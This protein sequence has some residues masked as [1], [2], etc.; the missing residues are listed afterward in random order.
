LYCHF[1]GAKTSTLADFKLP[2]HGTQE[3]AATCSIFHCA[4]SCPLKCIR[5]C[6]SSGEAME[7]GPRLGGASPCNTRARTPASWDVD[8]C[9]TRTKTR[10]PAGPRR[11]AA[12]SAAQEPT[13]CP[14]QRHRHMEHGQGSRFFASDVQP[15]IPPITGK[16]WGPIQLSHSHTEHPLGS[17][18]QAAP[19]GHLQGG[20]RSWG[21]CDAT[22]HLSIQDPVQ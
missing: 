20:R 13:C 10:P 16:V 15:Q 2:G 6:R 12:R 17:V 14:W 18:G 4:S 5:A 1:W 21:C 8:S 9:S 11:S 22:A 19:N 3:G 7:K